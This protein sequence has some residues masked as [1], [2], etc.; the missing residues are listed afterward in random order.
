MYKV[1]YNQRIVL[2]TESADNILQKSIDIYQFKDIESLR[3]KIDDFLEKNSTDILNVISHD[4]HFAFNE[5]SKLYILIEAAGGLVKN[6]NDEFLFIFRRN[7]WDLPKGKIEENE[8]PKS[9]AIREVEEECGICKPIVERELTVTYHTYQLD[10][11]KILKKTYWFEMIYK[12]SEE[13][14]P[15]FEE[16]ITKVVWLKDSEFKKVFENT[17]PSIIDVIESNNL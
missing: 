8:D 6:L 15:Q 14:K 17:F 13:L 3:E 9:G 5:F 7:K 11:R 1:F 16:E 2:F 10:E 12:G 4:I